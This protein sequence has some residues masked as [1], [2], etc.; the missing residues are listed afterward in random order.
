[1]PA[2]TRAA[3]LFSIAT[4]FLAAA[5]VADAAQRRVPQGF[6]GVMW[7]GA[8]AE[9]SDDRQAT[10]W[11][12]MAR[13]GVESVRTAFSW[14]KAQPVGGEPPSFAAT[15]RIVALAAARRIRVLPV[16]FQ[17]P[18][19]A[20]REPRVDSPPARIE[21]YTAYLEALVRRYGPQGSFWEE[22]PDLPRRPLR[23]WQ[24]WNEPHLDGYW[25]SD[26][27][28]AW[29]R[30]Y[31]ALLRISN[32]AL[33]RSD[34]GSV[35]VLAG[36]A[37]YVWR[38]LAKLYR[39]GIRGN[40]DVAAINFFT[41]RP[42]LVFKGIRLFRAG[43]RKGGEPRKPLW[44]TETTWPASRG[45]VNKPGPAWQRRWATTDAGMARRLGDLYSRTVHARR[46]LVLERVYWYTWASPYRGSDLFDYS[47]L[48]RWRDGSF[49]VRPALEAYA[50][51]A[52][53][54]QGCR[55]SAVGTC[56]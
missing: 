1:M 38:H 5:P 6:H 56:R 16:V 31:A 54:A 22:R 3:L 17:T 4:L 36:L 46:K 53:R 45:R 33:E 55:K 48:V 28:R 27:D 43:L 32:A 19:W 39:A 13:S 25:R 14:A 24:V 26:G 41:T 15:D 52:R 40:F 9:A 37:D 51:S 49:S 12:L 10:Q 29:A 50:A 18:L 42:D 35:T 20:A 23:E 30:E 34:P 44:L 7:D 11:D 2:V 21:D 8:A 47:G